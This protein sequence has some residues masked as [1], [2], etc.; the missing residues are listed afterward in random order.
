M[1]LKRDIAVWF[2]S[3]L[4]YR[5]YWS[6][7]PVLLLFSL[8]Y[9]ALVSNGKYPGL[10]SILLSSPGDGLVLADDSDDDD[11]DAGHGES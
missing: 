2:R 4:E 6:F 9:K 10:V 1:L 11:N 8:I 7:F 3:K 5:S